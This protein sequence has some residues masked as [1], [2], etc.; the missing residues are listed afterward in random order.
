MEK[1]LADQVE[2]VR[3]N[4][5]QTVS[6]KFDKIIADKKDIRAKFEQENKK[7]N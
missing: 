2:E 7:K 5:I 6:D 4:I 3:N 1:R